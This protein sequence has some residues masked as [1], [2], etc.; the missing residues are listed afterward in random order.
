MSRA[1]E[2]A[3]TIYRYLE[4]D[5]RWVMLTVSV[6]FWVVAFWQLTFP[7]PGF[8][9]EA[10]Q[11]GL[12]TPYFIR[13]VSAFPWW[14]V[15]LAGILLPLAAGPRLRQTGNIALVVLPLLANAIIHF[16][17]F[18][19]QSVAVQALWRAYW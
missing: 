5:R 16:S 7:L 4:L 8:L 11:V 12:R 13:E 3:R 1:I 2:N 14:V 15:A 18:D 9:H 17:L 19:A 6:L 10:D